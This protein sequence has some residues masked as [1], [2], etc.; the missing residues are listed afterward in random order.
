MCLLLP[1]DQPT[2]TTVLAIIG[3]MTSTAAFS[4]SY[5]YAAELFPTVLR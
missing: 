2:V 4:T 1:S 5:V 3:K